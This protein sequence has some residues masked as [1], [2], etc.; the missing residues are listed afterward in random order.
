M[1]THSRIHT[2]IHTNRTYRYAKI[3]L[4]NSFK[5]GD[6]NTPRSMYTHSRIHTHIHTNRTYRYAKIRLANSFKLGA[7][8][9]VQHGMHDG[10]IEAEMRRSMWR[11]ATEL[12]VDDGKNF[13]LTLQWFNA[14]NWSW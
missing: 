1:Y 7:R 10:H 4:A 2:H 6:I 11:R 8:A 5:L 3:R 9:Y 12:P 13:E 14:M